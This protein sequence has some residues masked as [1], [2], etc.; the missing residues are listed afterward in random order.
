MTITR[1][2]RQQFLERDYYTCQSCFGGHQEG[3]PDRRPEQR[4]LHV[5]HKVKTPPV[6]DDLVLV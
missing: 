1:E 4:H 6:S 5:H 3:F 2:L